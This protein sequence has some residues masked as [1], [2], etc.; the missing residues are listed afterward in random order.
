MAK[1]KYYDIT[2]MLKTNAQYMLLLGQRAN[3]KS[4][5]AK[6]TAIRAA[7][8]GQPF[9]YLRRWR[10]DIKP[11]SVASYF[12]D[13]PLETLAPEWEYINAARGEIYL[14][15]RDEKGKEIHGPLLGRYCAL[16]EAERYKSQTFIGYKYIVYEEFITDK[17]YI[18]EEPRLLQQLVST[19]ARD[20]PITVLMI[21]NT[22]SRV[23][24]Y[25]SEWCL[26]NVL[27][28]KQGTIEIYHFHT[29]DKTIVDVAVEYCATV[30]SKNTM[31][32]GQ[33][34]RQIVTGEWDTVAVPRLPRKQYEYEKV[35]EILVE[36]QKFKF[37]IELLV[38]NQNGGKICFVY[39]FTGSRKIDRV[40]T[41]AFNESPFVS[42]AL[43]PS[44]T[45]ERYIKDC[46]RLSKVCYSDNLTGSDFKHVLN[47]FHMI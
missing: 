43:D 7:L 41:D 33:A 14:A 21:G 12:G 40:L 27:K 47:A 4:Y 5:Q 8:N 15:K 29:D 35:Y 25:F 28:Q 30:Q 2:A 9:V 34:A 13:M 44:K 32:F 45:P 36:Y 6:L 10:E 38:E 31:F 24:P 16:N 26:E 46:F 23:C 42:S 20:K 17:T 22:L 11:K 18:P 3:G 19:I 37:V 1:K 39:P